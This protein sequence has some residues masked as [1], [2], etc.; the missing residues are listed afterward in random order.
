MT[1]HELDP[2]YSVTPRELLLKCLGSDVACPD[3]HLL[4]KHVK[5]H[6]L[7]PASL[8]LRERCPTASEIVEKLLPLALV[9]ALDGALDPLLQSRFDL[10]R[11]DGEPQTLR[12]LGDE[13]TVDIIIQLRLAES[14]E[15]IAGVLLDRGDLEFS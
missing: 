9:E 14:R 11:R 8:V 5:V 3:D 10:F 13:E 1:Q 15:K 12:F 7:T 6:S 2:A 4:H